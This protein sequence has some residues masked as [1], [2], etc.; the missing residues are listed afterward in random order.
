MALKALMMIASLALMCMPA[1][2][3]G[4]GRATIYPAPE[5]EPASEGY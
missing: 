3:D 5:G 1:A 4:K 2:A